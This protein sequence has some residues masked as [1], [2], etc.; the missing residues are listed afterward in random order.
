M[1]LLN[2]ACF[3]LTFATALSISPS[4]GLAEDTA[5]AAN[6]VDFVRDVQPIFRNHCYSCHGSE[7]QEAGL[8]LDS[9]KRAF[10]GGDSGVIL[11]PN[12]AAT[13]RLM[14]IVSGEGDEVDIMPPEGEGRPLTGA[15]IETLRRW[16][17]QGADWPAEADA[18][19]AAS[20]HWSFQ[21]L[22]RPRVPKVKDA[23][24]A[25]NEIDRFILA[26]LEKEAIS[27]SPEADRATLIRRIYLDLLGLPPA[28]N[29]VDRFLE[30]NS[31]DAYRR[32]VDRALDSKHYG[33]RWGR[34]WLDLARYADSDG[35]EKDR[36]RPWAWRYREWVIDALNADMPFDQFTVE[37]IAG[38]MLDDATVEQQVAA[39]FHRNTLHNTEG[40]TDKEEDRVKKTIDR[41]NTVGTTWLGL[42]V[43]C[44]QCHSHKYDPISQREYYSLY[45][46]F[47]YIAEKDVPAPTKSELD[48]LQEAKAAY[49]R[50]HARLKAAVA[51]YEKSD[52]AKAQAAW[53]RSAQKMATWHAIKPTKIESKKGAAFKIQVDQSV[54]VTGEKALSDIY[55]VAV[56]PET[57]T[58]SAVGLEVLPDKSLAK[59]GPG[60]AENGNFVLTT[61]GLAVA[62]GGSSDLRPIE[63]RA[64]RADFSQKD[65]EVEKAVNGD[66]KDGWAVSPEFGK[67]HVAVFELKEAISLKSDES[68]VVTLDQTYHGPEAHNIGRFRLFITGAAGPVDLDGL[69]A[70]VARA[71]QV[72]PGKRTQ[73]QGKTVSDYYRSIDPQLK[74]LEDAVAAHAKKAPGSGKTK[75]QSVVQQ[76]FSTR[77]TRVFP[78]GDFL[79]KKAGVQVTSDVPS[80]LPPIRASDD[81]ASR[82]DLARWLVDPSNPLT[83]RVTVNRIWQRHFGRGIV[84]SSDD[85]G[86]QG[87]PP[88]HPQLLDWLASE[89]RDNGWRLKHMHRLIVNSATYRQQSAM[90]TE[91]VDVDPENILLARQNR[92]RVEAEIV[93]DLALAVSGLLHPK[94]GGPSVRPPQ[95][96]EYSK[97]TY[98]NSAKWKT[99]AGGDRYR[100]GMYTFFQR[101]SPYPMLITFDSPDST[102]CTAQRSNSNTPL[103]ALTI[104][105]D[106]VFVECAQQLGRRIVNEAPKGENPDATKQS[107]AA[108]AFQLC[109]SRQPSDYEMEVLLE[110]YDEQ[111]SMSQNDEKL[112]SEIIGKAEM[113]SG[114]TPAE[115]SGWIAVG[116]TLLNL[117][118]F[119]TRE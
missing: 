1:R 82:L 106:P 41:T 112:T 81:R 12:K 15:Q 45:A 22:R 73:A 72:L 52:L 103:Q 32:M 70:T 65:W 34:H 33:E 116:R 63:I 59:R 99:S 53:E 6:M 9:K 101:T 30:D 97:L 51:E 104:W 46:F 111:V 7:K 38:D 2:L 24:W 90:R 28:P 80:V 71:L 29:E 84:A 77:E 91:L 64:A 55:T 16:I 17:E 67:R 62:T 37:Q 119:I 21:P 40:G 78:R 113:P 5:A 94:I 27:P 92:Q 115:L 95:P 76:S 117:D 93:R 8:R 74:R 20:D 23:S 61:F 4:L 68:L 89:F 10:E 60:R 118:E 11:T 58:I 110:L 114:V 49:Q 75:A 35:Y 107:R 96:T 57:E 56:Q 86:S 42:T 26:R 36:P 102:E 44:A 87:D 85:F 19:L 13:S 54:L 109:F 88:S 50:E 18:K 47:N 25:R 43:G 66:P 108:Y 79:Q 100:R 14:R 3:A 69:P 48:A 39:G 83:A 105:N 98:A 31:E